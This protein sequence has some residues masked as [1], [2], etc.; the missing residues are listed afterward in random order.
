VID[1]DILGAIHIPNAGAKGAQCMSRQYQNGREKTSYHQK[2]VRG[3]MEE[4]EAQVRSVVI[5]A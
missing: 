4:A 2:E 5:H 3:C 1:P